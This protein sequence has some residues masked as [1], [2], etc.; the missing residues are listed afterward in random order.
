MLLPVSLL[1]APMLSVPLLFAAL[2]SYP[3]PA[4]DA[5]GDG[6]YV[7]PTRPAIS[8]DALD[9]REFR[10]E[11]PGKVPKNTLPLLQGTAKPTVGMR[12]TVGLGRIENPWGLPSGFSAGVTDIFVK[13]PLGTVRAL[14]TLGLNV[15]GAGGW[16]Y[17]VRVTGA[18]AT[19]EGLPSEQDSAASPLTQKPVPMA[20]PTVTVEGTNLVIDTAIPSGQ[21]AY[22]VTN[23]VY[24]P[25]SADGILRP[26]TGPDTS[27]LQASRASA[28][29]PVDVL[30]APD[31]TAVYTLD[32]LA[33][34]GQTRDSRTL[35]LAGVGGVGLLLTVL[36]TVLVWRRR[37]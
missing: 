24:S 20:A 32:T 9:L 16:Q 3:D 17:H 6:G 26:S 15:R 31:D 10:A 13:S 4:G 36:A 37:T 34:V 29:A 27:A 30:A 11:A 5:R 33:P 7:L 35:L 23:S 8:A 2:F 28:P 12:F 21:Y 22:W 25:I 19:L 1:S 18:G 14:G